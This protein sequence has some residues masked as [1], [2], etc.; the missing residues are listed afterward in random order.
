MI[1]ER[2]VIVWD[3]VVGASGWL[4]CL[5]SSVYSMEDHVGLMVPFLGERLSTSRSFLSS[6]LGLFLSF[7]FI[8]APPFLPPPFHL[9][10]LSFSSLLIP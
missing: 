8:S 2:V 10:L 4:Y 1:N 9:I 5:C 3:A 6:L 7:L